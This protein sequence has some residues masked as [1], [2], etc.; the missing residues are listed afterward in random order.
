MGKTMEAKEKFDFAAFCSF[1]D[2]NQILDY[3]RS[4]WQAYAYDQ[5]DL[6]AASVTANTAIDMVRRLEEEF[7]REFPKTKDAE[8]IIMWAFGMRCVQKR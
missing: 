6:V 1:A 8:E 5:L 4:L 7:M 2:I 3:V